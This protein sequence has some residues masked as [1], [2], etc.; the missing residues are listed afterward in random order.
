MI[1]KVV[2]LEILMKMK[3]AKQKISRKKHLI[4]SSKEEYHQKNMLLFKKLTQSLKSVDNTGN[5]D[6]NSD[7]ALAYFLFLPKFGL[8]NDINVDVYTEAHKIFESELSKS[9]KNF[10]KKSYELE[11]K[12]FTH[13]IRTTKPSTLVLPIRYFKNDQSKNECIDYLLIYFEADYCAIYSEE[14]LKK[15][16]QSIYTAISSMS[17]HKQRQFFVETKLKLLK[18]FEDEFPSL[19]ACLNATHNCFGNKTI[20]YEINENIT[21]LKDFIDEYITPKKIKDLIKGVLQGK[22]D[23]KIN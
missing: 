23:Q 9:K 18:N 22:M 20:I 19:N 12:K 10:N 6:L 5:E 1:L 11:I 16:E 4:P 17:E 14:H 3:V 13:R 8:K 7:H 21:E 15:Y 2:S